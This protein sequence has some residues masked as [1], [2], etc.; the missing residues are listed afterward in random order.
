MT[1]EKAIFETVIKHG[2]EAAPEWAQYLNGQ[3]RTISEFERL[4]DLKPF[5]PHGATAAEAAEIRAVVRLEK[6]GARLSLKNLMRGAVDASGGGLVLEAYFILVEAGVSVLE[7]VNPESI[8]PER[9]KRKEKCGSGIEERGGM[10]KQE[11]ADELFQLVNWYAERVFEIADTP[12]PA[13]MAAVVVNFINDFFPIYISVL[14]NAMNELQTAFV[15][16]AWGEGNKRKVRWGVR[17]RR[18]R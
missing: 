2:F 9:Y 7:F 18:Y 16:S 1:P 15:K 4:L 17:E 10:W 12:R 8:N 11:H 5:I 3:L 14:E 13:F 6:E